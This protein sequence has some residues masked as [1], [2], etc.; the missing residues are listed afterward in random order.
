MPKTARERMIELLE[1]RSSESSALIWLGATDTRKLIKLL[2]ADRTQ[3]YR[4][5]LS[6]A[7][8]LFRFYEQSHLAKL[9]KVRQAS[10]ISP[11]KERRAAIK[12]V[13]DKVKRNA[14]IAEEI[15]RAI[16]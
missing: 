9:P 16:G 8:K 10:S 15:E 6:K 7:A 14:A 12:S 3:E 1:K 4:K 2:K 11:A 13:E 5:L